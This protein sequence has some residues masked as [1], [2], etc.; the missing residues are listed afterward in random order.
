MYTPCSRIRLTVAME[1]MH[2]FHCAI[3]FFFED[4]LICISGVPMNDFTPMK[5]CP[6]LKGTSN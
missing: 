6:G 3:E 5:N 1:T 2:L 4:K